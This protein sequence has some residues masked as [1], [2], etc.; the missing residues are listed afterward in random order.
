MTVQCLAGSTWAL[1]NRTSRVATPCFV[2]RL[3]SKS[4]QQHFVWN[5]FVR[6]KPF[7]NLFRFEQ[8]QKGKGSPHNV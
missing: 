8:S 3:L 2:F 5:F 7:D 1:F 6:F 4:L